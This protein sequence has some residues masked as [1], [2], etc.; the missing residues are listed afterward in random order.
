MAVEKTYF[1]ILD[2]DVANETLYSLST[3]IFNKLVICINKLSHIDLTTNEPIMDKFIKQVKNNT[4]SITAT[5]PDE[6]TGNLLDIFAETF[7]FKKHLLNLLVEYK[8]GKG[9]YKDIYATSIDNLIKRYSKRESNHP[10]IIGCNHK[11]RKGIWC[12][13]NVKSVYIVQSI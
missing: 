9:L 6:K 3:P 13:R 5:N 12:G 7:D 2:Q 11:M 4:L 8:Y 10:Q 1:Y